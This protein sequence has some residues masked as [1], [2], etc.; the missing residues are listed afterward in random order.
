MG[1]ARYKLPR[2]GLAIVVEKGARLAN[3]R[4]VDDI[5]QARDTGEGVDL[6]IATHV[7]LDVSWVQREHDDVVGGQIDCQRL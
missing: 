7:G 6:A 5:Q 4:V 2:Q 3:V 1:S